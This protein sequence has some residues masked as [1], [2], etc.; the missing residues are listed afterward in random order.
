MFGNC[1]AQAT[2]VAAKQPFPG[3][4]KADRTATG[5]LL[6]PTEISEPAGAEYPPL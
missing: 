5:P 6:A 2:I 4:Q 3:K 1:C